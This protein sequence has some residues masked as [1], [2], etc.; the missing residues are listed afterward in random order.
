MNDSATDMFI[1]M[2][3]YV[4]GNETFEAY[5]QVAYSCVHPPAHPPKLA[6]R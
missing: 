1:S 2:D 5:R 3:T 6:S 4:Q